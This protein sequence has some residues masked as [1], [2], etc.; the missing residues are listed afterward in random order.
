MNEEAQMQPV[1]VKRGSTFRRWLVLEVV[2]ILLIGFAVW[3]VGRR[4]FKMEAAAAASNSRIEQLTPGDKIKVV[5][6]LKSADAMRSAQGVLL[7]K[8][9]E[10]LYRRTGTAV[11]M[12][13]DPNVPVVM[14]KLAD[15]HAGAVVHVTGTVVQDGG[16]A[17]SQVV[18]LTGYV[19]VQ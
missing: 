14:G 10:D 19:K 15:I 6:E 18:I 12:T 17:A 2:A 11:R 8:Q 4:A 3:N 9:G 1:Q 7:E 5:L 16:I 13:F